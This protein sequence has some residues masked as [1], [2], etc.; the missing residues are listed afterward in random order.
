MATGRL[1]AGLAV[2]TL[3]GCAVP[4]PP[5]T[6]GPVT[7][8]SQAVVDPV[9]GMDDLVRMSRADLEALYRGAEI[10][11]A[12]TG[13]ARGR[14][15]YD[16]GTRLTVPA[17]RLIHVLWQGKVFKS[18]GMMVNRV[19]GLRAVHARV[20]VGE[21][22]LDGKPSLILDYCG[23][24]RIFGDAR[25][26]VRELSPGLY[27]GLTHVRRDTGP[28]LTMFFTLDA[29]QPARRPILAR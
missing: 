15:I 9:R 14:A 11:N 27:L 5:Q 7:C 22:W 21:S 26:E 23:T 13:F 20:Y 12:P 2:V 1:A 3:L 19:F 29:R 17:S 28:E 25:D 10:G 6:S 16:P 4:G 8:H 18:D 24:S